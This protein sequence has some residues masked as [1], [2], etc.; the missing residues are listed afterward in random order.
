MKAGKLI[1]VASLFILLVL[2]LFFVASH[3]RR[4]ETVWCGTTMGTSYTIRLVGPMEPQKRAWFRRSISNRLE[5][6]NQNLSVWESKSGISHFNATSSTNPISVPRSLTRVLE[7]ALEISRSTEGAFDPTAGPLVNLWGFGPRKGRD[8]PG[9][10]LVRATLQD[11]GYRHL[12]IVSPGRLRKNR[13]ELNLDLGGIAKGHGVDELADLLRGNGIANFLVEI[14]G[15]VYAQG[16]NATGDAWVVG[17]EHPDPGKGFYAKMDLSGYAVATS[18][19]YQNYQ[20]DE[21]GDLYSHIIDPRTGYPSQSRLAG[22][23]VTASS[24][25]E[26]DGLATA[27]F[28][29]GR[30]KGLAWVER[31]PDCE[32]LFLWRSGSGKELKET[33]SS[34]FCELT[35]YRD[36]DLL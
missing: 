26:A 24:C 6:L 14:G 5:E 23:T 34:G 25:M 20:V 10:D 35:A 22:V 7:S 32:A 19:D 11:T 17:V 27:L 2:G 15:E 3:R 33:L 36:V 4:P 12:R 29:M 13:P 18:G 30:E 28:V 16:L 1:G 9:S 8:S 21:D 31:H